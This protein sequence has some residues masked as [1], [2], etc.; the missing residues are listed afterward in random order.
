VKQTPKEA[1]AWRNASKAIADQ[2]IV[3][4]RETTVL[5]SNYVS[6]KEALAEAVK[7]IDWLRSV[8]F[9]RWTPADAQKLEEWREL[10]R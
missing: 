9:E 2:T 10:V 7:T 6:V 5:A 1:A 3:H 8:A 4:R